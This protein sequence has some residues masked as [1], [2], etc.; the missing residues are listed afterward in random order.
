[1]KA[2]LAKNGFDPLMGA[3]PMS[4]LIQDTIRTALADE[5]L[6]GRLANGGK[7]TVDVDTEGKTRLV[8]DEAKE[9]SLA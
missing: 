3:R 1:L 5:L 8:F 6:F 4:R 7:V 2:Y 9:E